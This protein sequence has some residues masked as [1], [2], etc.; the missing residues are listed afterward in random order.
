MEAGV[1][2][3]RFVK[4]QRADL[5]IQHRLERLDVVDDPVVGALRD[6]QDAR[7]TFRMTLLSRSCERVGLDLPLNAFGSEFGLRNRTDDP[8]VVP[9]GVRKTGTAPVMMIECRIDL[10]QLRSTTTMSPDATV[11]CQ[12]ILFEVDVPLVTKK[13]WSALKI[14]AALRFRGS[15]GARMVEQ[16][17]SSSTALQTS[18]VACS[19]QR[20]GGTSARPGS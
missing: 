4:V 7:L 13:Q 10:W 8:Q 12:T 16:L 11:E 14:R 1:R 5:A 17:P 6:C 20:T 9:G 3:P 18:P 2:Q 19:H 15:H